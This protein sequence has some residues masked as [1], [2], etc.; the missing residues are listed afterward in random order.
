MHALPPWPLAQRNRLDGFDRAWSLHDAAQSRRIESAAA[1]AL[2]AHTLMRRA[3]LSVARLALAIAPHA[4]VVWIAAG[5]G[6]NGGDGLE[7]ALH[8]KRAGRDVHVT[9]AGHPASLP[10]DAATSWRRAVDAGVS[11]GD[12][13]GAPPAPDLAID[14]LFGLGASREPEGAIAEL[15]RLLNAAMCPRLAIDLPSGVAA[16]SGM[17][18]GALAVRATHTLSLLTLKPGLFTGDGRELAGDIWYDDLGCEAEAAAVPPRAQLGDSDSVQ[19]L[20]PAR[21]HDGHKGRY[22]DVLVVGGARGMGG[23]LTLAARAAVAGGAGRVF[24]CPLDAAMPPHDALCPEILWRAHAWQGD[25]RT[26]QHATTVVGCG[27]GD[28]VRDA[29]PVLLSRSPRLVIDADGLNAIAADHTL[30]SLLAARGARGHGTVLTPHPLEAARLLALPGADRVQANR[31]AAAQ[32]LASRFDCAVLLKGSGTVI[33]APRRVPAV[34]PTG[35]A[36]LA[37]GGTG[38]VLAGWL[39]GLWSASAASGAVAEAFV[40]ARAAAWLHGAAAYAGNDL[41]P[42]T[43]SALL[44]GLAAG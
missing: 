22:G 20:R 6:N 10:A 28:A 4:R 41:A 12:A 3:G 35:N 24:A 19:P 1:A 26:W 33:A 30:Q 36:R 39:G 13:I 11:V 7:A 23:A 29:L 25:P 5:P 21:G 42:L 34:N 32:S 38:D 16:D 37:G 8:L 14:A 15:V 17:P 9:L 18:L 44:E 27:G 2:P 43:A 31:L 40:A